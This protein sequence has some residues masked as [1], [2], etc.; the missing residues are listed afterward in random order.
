MFKLG[1]IDYF[2]DEWH[3][4][5]YPNW[6][7]EAS[8]GDM[9]VTHAFG[10]ID[11]PGGKLTSAAWCEKHGVVHCKTMEELIAACDGL[12]VLSPDNPEMHL[13]LCE[14]PLQSGK[15]TYVDKTFS[16]DLATAQAIFDIAAQHNTPCYSTSALRYANEYQG[17]DTAAI[18]ALRSYGPGTLGNYSVHQLEPLC[19]LMQAAPARVLCLTGD[20][21]VSMLVQFADGRHATVSNFEQ[22]SGFKMDICTGQG[23]TELTIQSDFFKEFIKVLVQFFRDSKVS[24]PHADTL[25]IMALR[26]AALRAAQTPGQWVEVPG[27]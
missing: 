7:R 3:A 13:Q 4:N 17:I 15:P 19:M 8:G 1:F 26:E 2:L 11:G 10:L 5:Q 18:T 21:C 22:G 27:K 25:R 12:I 20:K 16:P 14:K 6:I 9:A 23:V 24:V